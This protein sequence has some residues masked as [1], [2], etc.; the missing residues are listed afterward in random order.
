[1]GKKKDGKKKRSSSSDS[2]DSDNRRSKTLSKFQTFEVNLPHHVCV[3]SAAAQV[4]YEPVAPVKSYALSDAFA[5][6]PPPLVATSVA[7]PPPPVVEQDEMVPLHLISGSTVG[8][9]SVSVTASGPDNVGGLI[10]EPDAPKEVVR[11]TVDG[12][13]PPP[14]PLQ[15]LSLLS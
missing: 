11:V 15:L 9:V 4:S 3:A 14:M 13:L 5:P 6:P 10:K 8:G 2:S 1:M 12:A 7:A